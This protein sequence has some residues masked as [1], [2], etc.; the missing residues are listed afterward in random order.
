MEL[1][2]VFDLRFAPGVAVCYA[3]SDEGDE[4]HS[5]TWTAVLPSRLMFAVLRWRARSRVPIRILVLEYSNTTSIIGT[6]TY[7]GSPPTTVLFRYQAQA[8][9]VIIQLVGKSTSSCY[10]HCHCHCY[11][12]YTV[13]YPGTF[14]TRLPGSLAGPSTWP[15]TSWL[16]LLRLISFGP[17]K[18]CSKGGATS[19]GVRHGYAARNACMWLLRE[20]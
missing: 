18:E 6:S 4:R 20:Y 3:P 2:C 5:N 16:V 13:C 8:R 17:G 19:P 14:V 1:P 11:Y 9:T 7:I 12:F 10:C 15:C